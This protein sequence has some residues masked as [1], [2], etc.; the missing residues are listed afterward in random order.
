[1]GNGIGLEGNGVELGSDTEVFMKSDILIY[2]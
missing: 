1:M 2:A